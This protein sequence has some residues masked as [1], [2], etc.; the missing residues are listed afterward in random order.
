[1]RVPKL[2]ALLA[3]V[4]VLL[5]TIALYG[6]QAGGAFVPTFNYTIPGSWTFTGNQTFTGTVSTT[7]GT[8]SGAITVTAATPSITTSAGQTNTGFLQINGKTSGATKI[9]TADATAQTVTISTAAQTSGA[10]T[11][12]IPDQAGVSRNFVF[13]SLTQSLSNKTF[14]TAGVG[15]TNATSGTITLAAPTGALG[16]PT[17]TLP[18]YSGGAVVGFS[19]GSTG[20]GNQT[21]SPTAVNGLMHAYNGQ[22]TL[23]SNAATITFPAAFTST[24]SFFCVANDV[25]TRAN[26]VQMVPA[27]AS[28]ATITN[29]TGASDV[30]QWLCLGQ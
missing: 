7:G 2:P 3:V 27:S 25:T 23:S 12:T 13:D 18:T 10:S 19:C 29:T 6:Q 15:F 30:I 1:M 21:C 9:T 5:G 8:T 20:S 16:T 11:L 22:S 26:P 28:T 14:P 24:T 4:I 17:L